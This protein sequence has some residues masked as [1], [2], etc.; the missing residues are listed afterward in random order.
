MAVKDRFDELEGGVVAAAVTLSIFVSLFPALLVGTAI[1]GF[2]ANGRVDLANDII[3]RLGL[4]GTAA[5]VMTEAI[6]SAQQSRRAASVVGFIGLAWSALGVV[7]AI[8]RAVDKAWQLKRGG[9][10]DRGIAALWLLMTGLLL[11]LSIAL[12]GVIV[13]ILPGWAAPLAIIP[14]VAVNIFVFWLTFA[15]LGTQKVGWRPLLPGAMFAGIGLQVLTLLGAYLVPRAVANS[16]ALYGSLGVVF[17]IL[18]WLFFFGRLLVYA[19]IL[20]VVLYER[21]RGTVTVDIEAPRIPG[22]VP[23]EADRGGVVVATKSTA[24]A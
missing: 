7:M 11:V 3:N 19:S 17:A 24:S 12:T 14:T 18:A 16:S 23:V 9:I 2:I 8:E 21:T 10:K 13:S 5:D 6:S 20:N 15:M 22:E 4:S 1:I